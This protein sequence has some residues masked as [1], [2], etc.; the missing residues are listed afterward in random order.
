MAIRT[1]LL[2][3]ALALFAYSSAQAGIVIADLE[4][5][6]NGG[7]FFAKVTFT[8]IAGG[9]SVVADISDPINVG[10][11]QGD[12]LEI[13]FNVS[14]ESVL[15]SLGVANLNPANSSTLCQLANSCDVY[16]GAGSVGNDLDISLELGINGSDE[17][18]I[19]TYSFD[20]LGLTTSIIVDQLVVMRVQSI[21]GVA[22]F[23]AG[24]SKLAGDGPGTPVPEPG[25]LTLLALGLAGLAFRRR[26]A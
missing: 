4:D 22:G 3:A 21:E 19:E 26:M 17:G 6:T 8:D 18:F 11:T 12:I 15:G 13:G 16:N 14:D 25:T 10:L 20:L 9:V 5:A 7:G 2:G 24:S 23:T 1:I